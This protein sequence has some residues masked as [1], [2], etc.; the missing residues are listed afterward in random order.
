MTE[1]GTGELASRGAASRTGRLQSGADPGAAAC[2]RVTAMQTGWAGGYFLTRPR[3]ATKRN[4]KRYRTQEPSPSRCRFR[5]RSSAFDNG[6]DN[7][8]GLGESSLIEIS[9]Q[10]VRLKHVT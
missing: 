9:A 2:V 5:Y 6:N 8:L 10:P 7:E 3:A 1:K 4:V